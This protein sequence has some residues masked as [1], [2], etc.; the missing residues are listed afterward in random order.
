[1]HEF[2]K[3]LRALRDAGKSIVLITHKLREVLDVTDRITVLHQGLVAGCIET[4]D[5]T[6][7]T[8][9]RLM[10][11][12]EVLPSVQKNQAKPGDTILQVENLIVQDDLGQGAV[13][14]LS[15][16]VR[17]GE[18][19]GIAGVEGNGQTELVEAITGLRP[20]SGGRVL[21]NGQDISGLPPQALYRRGLA[22]VPEDRH[23]VGMVLDLTLAENSI[24]GVHRALQFR[25]ILDKILWSRVYPYTRSLIENFSIL[26]S[27]L[28]APAKSLSGGNQQKLI[29]AREFE[30]K[31][32]L[33]VAVQ[34]TRG[35]DVS[36]TQYI[37]DRLVSL[38]DQ[39]KAVLLVSADLDEIFQLSDRIAVLCE[40]RFMGLAAPEELDSEKIGLMMGGMAVPA[41]AAR[42]T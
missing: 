37:R 34:P 19:L 15:F 4:K 13:A 5:A 27:N 10:V 26:A 29:L 20:A 1:V 11:G 31:P 24:L 25:G 36:A 6:P 38:R 12:R 23:K 33:V 39:G 14:S 16:E 21:M 17:A 18:I 7:E 3:T 42:Q 8:L 22:H 2:F 28:R 40:G 9:A 30:K 32:S 35:L 41:Q